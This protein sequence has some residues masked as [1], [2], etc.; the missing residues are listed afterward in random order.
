MLLIG[1]PRDRLFLCPVRR[2]SGG[3][4]RCQPRDGSR[5]GFGISGGRVGAVAWPSAARVAGDGGCGAGSSRARP[6]ELEPAVADPPRGAPDRRPVRLFCRAFDGRI[7]LTACWGAAGLGRSGCFPGEAAPPFR[8]PR[9]P[10]FCAPRLKPALC[11]RG[12]FG[13]RTRFQCPDARTPPS[14]WDGGV[15]GVG[16]EKRSF[17]IGRPGGDRLSR[18]LR[19]SIIGAGAFHGRVRNGIGCGRPART[20]RSANSKGVSRSWCF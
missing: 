12:F 13:V 10:T 4:E 15:G 16:C 17:A 5:E 14:L 1:R 18:V 8:F 19:R 6:G 20:T 7:G 3:G 11:G 2:D 9:R